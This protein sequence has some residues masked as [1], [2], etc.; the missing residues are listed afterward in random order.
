MAS[1]A[2]WPPLCPPTRLR[3]PNRKMSSSCWRCRT[4][5]TFPMQAPHPPEFL[6]RRKI[7]PRVASTIEGLI[8]RLGGRPTLSH[9]VGLG[10]A[11]A[12]SGAMHDAEGKT[13]LMVASD[14]HPEPWKAFGD[15]QLADSP[16]SQAEAIKAVAAAK[17]DVDAAYRIGEEEAVLRTAAAAEPPSRVYFALNASDLAGPAAQ[18]SQSA[19]GYLLYHPEARLELVGHADPIGTAASNEALGL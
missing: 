2:R 15:T 7:A 4:W 16:V 1:R 8:T 13:G 3:R 5:R 19:A 14:A 6:F 11:G 12:I 17:A 10:I 18:A 9:W